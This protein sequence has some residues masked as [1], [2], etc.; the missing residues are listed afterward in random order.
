MEGWSDDTLCLLGIFALVSLYL[1]AGLVSRKHLPGCSYL[2]STWLLLLCLVVSEVFSFTLAIWLLA[3]LSFFA[4][5]EYSSLVDIRLQDRLGILGSYL[6]I[7]FMT[8]FIESDWYGMFIV[9]IPVYAFL[10]IPL[11]VTLGGREREGT[12]FSVGA[13][14]FGLLLA[15]YCIGHVG[16]LMLY[17]AWMAAVLVFSVVLCDLWS[18]VL[19]GWPG[20]TGWLLRFL[21]PIPFT[22]SLGLLLSGWSGIPVRH[23]IVLGILIPALALAGHHTFGY[24]KTDLGIRTANPLPGRGRLLD[25]LQSLFFAAPIVFHYIRYYLK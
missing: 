5:R 24:V 1:V 18:Y 15:V 8:V 14:N 2:A 19:K 4:L 12:V 16:Y 10:A 17:S 21:L 22:I 6:A 9:S 20:S 3:F 11:L 23:S 7:P 13:I 25:H